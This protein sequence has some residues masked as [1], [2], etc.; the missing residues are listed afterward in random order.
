MR[1]YTRCATFALS[2]QFDLVEQELVDL[3]TEPVRDDDIYPSAFWDV[4]QEESNVRFRAIRNNIAKSRKRQ[5]S[6]PID[7]SP[8]PCTP[9]QEALPKRNRLNFVRGGPVPAILDLNASP[10]FTPEV[11]P[12]GVDEI[13]DFSDDENAQRS[14]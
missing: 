10:A 1:S 3:N 9:T 6:P 7:P 14:L 2:E 13:E 5:R 12:P 8:P 11:V 4:M